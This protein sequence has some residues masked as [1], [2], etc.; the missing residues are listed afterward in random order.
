MFSL[1]A[2]KVLDEMVDND[3]KWFDEEAL[4][5]KTESYKIMWLARL[6]YAEKLK[7]R[8]TEYRNTIE[9]EVV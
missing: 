9:G 4:D 8:I 6:S 2:L 7:S 1:E 5:A 3:I